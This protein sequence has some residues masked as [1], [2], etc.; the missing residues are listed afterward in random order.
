[1]LPRERQLRLW[2]RG[3][4]LT[5][6]SLAERMGV[7]KSAL[8]KW[9]VSCSEPLPEKRKAELLALGLPEGCVP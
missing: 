5:L 7:H 1:M 2:L 4:G 8:G 9:L 6:S 3:Q